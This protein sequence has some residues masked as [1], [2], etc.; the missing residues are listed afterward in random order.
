MRRLAA[1][2][3]RRDAAST[4]RFVQQQVID[5]QRTAGRDGEVDFVDIRVVAGVGVTTSLLA[6]LFGREVER[7]FAA[8]TTAKPAV[9]ELAGSAGDSGKAYRAALVEERRGKRLGAAQSIIEGQFIHDA[10]TP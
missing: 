1:S 4:L 10:Q 3:T 7:I 8:F 5:R 6:A 2:E 9:V